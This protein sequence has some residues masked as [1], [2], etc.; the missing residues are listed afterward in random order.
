MKKLFTLALSLLT[1]QSFAQISAGTMEDWHDYN[2]DGTDLEAPDGWVGSDSAIFAFNEQFP[3][4]GLTPQQQILRSGT[5]H[6]GDYSARM[7]TV[8]IGSFLGLFGGSI[9]NGSIA[10]DQGGISYQGGAPVNERINFVNAWVRYAPGVSDDSASITITAIVAGSNGDSIVGSGAQLIGSTNG[11]FEFHGAFVNYIDGTIVPEKIQITFNSS[12]GTTPEEG[13]LLRV[14]DVQL[15]P[16][17]VKNTQKV[18]VV[19]CYPN[20]ST[21]MV[22]VFNTLNEE[23]T[24]KAFNINGQEVAG[25][26]FKGNSVLDL[27]AQPSGVYFYNVISKDGKAVQHGKLTI[28]K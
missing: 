26:R 6:E 21:G 24:I 28:V 1:F 22:S 17:S 10:F 23:V 15:S 11:D 14:D 25:K 20:P 9:S 2:V 7:E 12:G 27:T 18:N 5:H 16:V 13:S 8:D 4:L 3:F 19:K